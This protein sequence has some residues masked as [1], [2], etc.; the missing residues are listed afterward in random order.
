VASNLSRFK[1]DM[2]LNLVSCHQNQEL[3]VEILTLNR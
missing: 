3:F 1:D 2:F